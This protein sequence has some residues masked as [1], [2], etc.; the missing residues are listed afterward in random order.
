MKKIKLDLGKLKLK[1]ETI[2][3]LLSNESQ[4]QLVGGYVGKTHPIPT[5]TCFTDGCASNPPKCDTLFGFPPCTYGCPATEVTCTCPTDPA[6]DTCGPKETCQDMCT[7]T[8]YSFYTCVGYQGE[9]HE[10]CGS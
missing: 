10:N 3:S 1:K 8:C 9:G 2:G 6:L 7:A 5:C 4:R